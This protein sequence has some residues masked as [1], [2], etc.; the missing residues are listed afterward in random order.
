LSVSGRRCVDK[1]LITDGGT[2]V[3]EV[4]A[5]RGTWWAR[6]TMMAKAFTMTEAFTHFNGN[7]SS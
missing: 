6:D 5:A 2:G 4:T 1:T 7:K 3:K